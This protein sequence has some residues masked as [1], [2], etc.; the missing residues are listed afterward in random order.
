MRKIYLDMNIYNRP[1][2]DQSQIRIKLETTAI[3]AVF[4]MVKSGDLFLVWSFVLDYENSL[5]PYDDIR[6][7]IEMSAYLASENVMA[8]EDIRKMAKEYEHKGIK[9]RDA[10]HIACA[11]K[12]GAEYFLT[13]DDKIVKKAKMLG[14]NLKIINPIDFARKM[15]VNQY[16]TDE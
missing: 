7:E 8:S 12:A 6:M 9:P 13:C 10:L 1:F 5:N 14:V 16:A 11:L 3:F 15:E 2:D 4:Q